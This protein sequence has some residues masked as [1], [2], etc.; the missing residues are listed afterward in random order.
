MIAVGAASLLSHFFLIN[1]SLGVFNLIPIPPLDGRGILSSL[2]PP[3]F[4]AGMEQFQQFGFLILLVALYT[5]IVGKVLGFFIPIALQIVFL[6]T[7]IRFI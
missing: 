6:G 4:E 1:V 5:G 2:L 7:D 3:S